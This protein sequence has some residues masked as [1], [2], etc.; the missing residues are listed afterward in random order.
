MSH[1]QHSAEALTAERLTPSAGGGRAMAFALLL[2]GGIA[3]AWTIFTIA[4]ADEDSIRY[5][6]ALASY[7]IGFMVALGFSLGAM[8]FTMILH[9]VNAGW[10]A[11]IRRQ[12][13]NMMDMIGPVLILFAPVLIF[14]FTQH[15]LW[16]WMDPAHVT[17]DVIFEHKEPFLNT[18]FFLIRVGFYFLVWL[19]LSRTLFSFS[20]RQDQTGDPALTK[21]ARRRSSYGILLFAFTST[22][23]AFDWEM[24]LDHHWFSTMYGVY[25]FAGAIGAALALGTLLM[26]WLTRKNMPLNGL[27]TAEHLHDLG[28]LLFAFSVFWA[29]IGFSQYFLIWYA[30]IPEETAWFVRRRDDQWMPYS[31]ALAT[32]RFIIPFFVLMPRP[33]RR[34]RVILGVMSLWI[35]GAQI[36]DRF[37]VIRPQVV[38][39][40][41]EPVPSGL[42]EVVGVLGP[43]ALFLGLL[44]LRVS[45]TPAAPLK[46]PRLAESLHHKNYV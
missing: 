8:I 25:H 6:R 16:H 27:V 41:G 4:T 13:E 43:V 40:G 23:A 3:A 31:V 28:K 26:L 44:M 7:H 22:F 20:R 42:I 33:F 34:N 21:K 32:C 39:H 15:P 35:I 12:F 14:S 37:W 18:T 45:S 17:G 46:D 10:S 19:W 24:S 9:Q 36:L 2:I 29:Y 1:H 11:L 30:N 5:Q 38:Q